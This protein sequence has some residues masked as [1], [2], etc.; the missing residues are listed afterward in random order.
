MFIEMLILRSVLHIEN[1]DF[2]IRVENVLR[3]VTI[4]LK[5]QM[6]SFCSNKIELALFIYIVYVNK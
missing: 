1:C 2:L 4:F 3:N 6:F 5:L